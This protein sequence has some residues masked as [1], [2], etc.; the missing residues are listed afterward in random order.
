MNPFF[1]IIMPAYNAASFLELS[2]DSLIFQNFKNF[3]I[4]LVNDGS[5]DDTASI[6]KKYA[7]KDRRILFVD[8]KNE[9]VAITRNI[10]LSMARGE[11]IMFVD[12]DDII[13]PNSLQVIFDTLCE[14]RVELLRYEYKTID[15]KGRD[16]YPNFEAKR[17]EKY[18]GKIL[19]PLSFMKFIMGTEYQLCF[20]IF[21]RSVLKK[22]SI[23]F[24]DGCTFNEDTLFLIQYFSR[25]KTCVY[26]PNIVYG[27]RKTS[28]AVTSK[29][30]ERNFR[31]VIRVFYSILEVKTDNKNF[32]K[33]VKAVAE[34]L[35]RNLFDNSFKKFDPLILGKIASE[36]KTRPV[37]IDWKLYNFFGFKV[38][39]ILDLFRKIRR[40]CYYV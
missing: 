33:E 22:Y 1:S 12:S 18:V 26:V 16:L 28:L 30:T 9:G 38:W 39:R 34:R 2:L 29:F 3:E 17:R 6:C 27:Y 25:A 21:K 35:G 14:K 36:C 19:D 31:D 32:N 15:G 23:L 11:Y 20:N 8:K 7:Q 10:A 4:I 5:T 24:L 40:R 13:Y 37:T